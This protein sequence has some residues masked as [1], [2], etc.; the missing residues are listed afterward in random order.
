MESPAL[1]EIPG[2]R[3][4]EC[5]GEGSFGVVFAASLDTAPERRFAT[6]VLRA[7]V[8]LREQEL[9]RFVRERRTGRARSHPHIVPV[10]SF[11]AWQNTHYIV[12]ELIDGGPLTERLPTRHFTPD[13]IHGNVAAARIDPPTARAARNDWRAGLYRRCDWISFTSTDSCTA[14]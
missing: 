11:G 9:R 10:H 8:T 13:N 12:M 14:M 1:P 3:L 6:R 5:I 7:D 2:Y 4:L